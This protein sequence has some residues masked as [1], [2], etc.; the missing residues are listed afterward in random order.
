MGRQVTYTMPARGDG[1]LTGN[2][3]DADRRA[4][5]FTAVARLW[6]AERATAM[7]QRDLEAEVQA[8]RAHKQGALADAA[9]A[10]LAARRAG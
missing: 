10:E 6:Q 4:R 3:A 8:A 1:T 2:L 9:L 7:A 5:L